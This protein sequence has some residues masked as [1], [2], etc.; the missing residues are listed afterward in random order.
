[1][2]WEKDWDGGG[3]GCQLINCGEQYCTDDAPAVLQE[4]KNI[5]NYPHT[6]QKDEESD[7]LSYGS[8]FRWNYAWRFQNGDNFFTPLNFGEISI[9]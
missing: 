4:I 8:K 3:S 9:G 2:S 5:Y 7:L 6:Y 1:M